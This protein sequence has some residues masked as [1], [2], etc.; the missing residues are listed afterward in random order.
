M[1]TYT[2]SVLAGVVFLLAPVI[3]VIPAAGQ[4][5]GTGFAA[6]VAETGCQSKYSDEKKAD[7]FDAKYKADIFDAKYK[8]KEMT[9]TGEVAT[10]GKGDLTIKI[11]P[12]TLTFDLKVKL[13]DAKATY[14]LEKGQ[15][16][17]VSFVMRSA[18]GCF[19]S[20]SGDQGVIVRA[21]R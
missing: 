2:K 3:T 8:D 14:D 17:T 4:A 7:I 20:Y 16:V 11:L 6:L 21:Q 15:H 10:V 12:T 18:G 1:K 5:G 13:S 19:L 9:V